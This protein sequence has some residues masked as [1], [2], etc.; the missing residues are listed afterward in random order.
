M[1]R[2]PL[3]LAVGLLVAASLLQAAAASWTYAGQADATLTIVNDSDETI[4][5]VFVMLFA[6]SDWGAD[7][8]GG[9]LPQGGTLVLDLPADVY[10]VRLL[11]C[12]GNEL[13]DRWVYVQESGELRFTEHDLCSSFSR[14]GV[15]LYSQSRYDEALQPLEAALACC[16]EG[17]DRDGEGTALYNIGAVYYSQ[18]T[19]AG[20]LEAYGQA[21]I[22]T[23]EVGD[24]V[25]EGATLN[26]IGF[27]YYAQGRYAEAFETYQQ[28][29]AIQ[30]E[31]GDQAGEARTL[32]NIGSVY[33]NQGRYAEAF[34]T[35]QQ[36]LVI[37]RDVG[38]R[39][40]E[41][42]TL[43][44][45]GSVYHNQGQYAEAF[46]TYQQALAIERDVGD[47]AGEARALSNI[48]S[49]YHNQGRYPE[50][51][52]V[53]GQALAIQ[54]EV[55]DRAGEAM[56][57][58]N[59]GMVFDAQ[60]RH[61]EALGVHQQALAIQREAGDRTGEAGTL[62]DIGSVYWAQGRYPEALEVNGQALAIQREV[63]DRAGEAV[64]LNNIGTVFDAQG[65]HVEALGVHQQALAI[66]REVGS[67]AGE[68]ATLHN[69]G[70]VYGNQGRYA[71]AIAACEEALAILREVG[72]RSGEGHTLSG[73]GSVYLAQGRCA[74]A[75][76]LF[77]RALAIEREVGDRRGQGETR[78]NVGNIYLLQG[79]YSEALEAYQKALAIHREVGNRQGEGRTLSSIGLVYWAQGRYPEA[80]DV[81]GQALAIQREVG[82]RAAE[83]RTLND[84]GAVYGA[85][86]RYAEALE[87]YRQALAV[88]REVGD[89]PSQGS[90]L[91]NMGRVLYD[92]DRHAEAL[93][94]YQQALAIEREVGD[95]VSEGITLS[96]I[97]LAYE[98]QGQAEQA[99]LYFRQ[100]MNVFDSLRT[101]AGSEAGRAGVGAQ[102]AWLYDRA[103]AL[104]HKSSQDETAFRT[105]ERG[106]ARAFLD[107]ISTGHVELSD[108]E[109]ADLLACEQETYAV[110]QAAQDALAKARALDP[111]DPALVA[112][113]EAQLAQS[114]T[115]YSAALAAIEDR[116]DQLA[117]LVPGRSTVLGLPTVQAL[118]D[119]ETTLLSYYVL[120]DE[121]SLA[122]L[123]T[124]DGFSVVD[125]PEATPANLGC[126]VQ[127]LYR[128]PN[129]ENPS[130]RPLQDLYAWLVAPLADQIATPR[131]GIIPH[132]ELNYVPFAALSDGQAYWGEEHALFT[133]SSAS[134]LPFIQQNA[135]QAHG[136]GA[137]VL[138]NPASGEAGL[139]PLVYAGEEAEGVAGLLGVGAL[140]GAEASET[141]LRTGVTGVGV[142]HLAAHGG[143]NT[144][145]PLYSTIYLAAGG[146]DD[147][148]L[149]VHEM[150]GLDL[151]AADLVVLSA[152]QSNLGELSAGDEWVGMTRALLFAGTPTV[153]AS[154]W[155]V[156]DKAA[157][158]LM[159]AFY[160]HWQSGM[161]KAEAL[162]AAQAEIR[163]RYPSPFYWA[164]FVL[165][166]DPGQAAPQAGP[167][168]SVAPS[169]TP[170]GSP[171]S[172]TTGLPWWVWVLLAV[173]VAGM[174]GLVVWRWRR[175][176]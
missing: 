159:M 9:T 168:P 21:L 24:E 28:A 56:T 150:Y 6:D 80:L 101:V 34:E 111:A 94:A 22:I 88:E 15:G 162:Q 108:N 117:A 98:P 10:D 151:K 87:A 155:S 30:R 45:I 163:A 69:I 82:D 107:S 2:L 95:R 52:E 37:Q 120:G 42:R 83:G 153:V 40:G 35:Y 115:D 158:E 11:D 106:R 12:E 86:R 121:G 70:S 49:A 109:A 44:N 20:A 29:L 165:S 119:E 166:G 3:L 129:L 112:D 17:G 46:E 66:E 73:M 173:L 97:G 36:A 157:G 100:A 91:N 76:H 7:R 71:E 13:L 137:L 142:V 167:V 122:F 78:G 19:Y 96:N 124:R 113:L 27:V 57:L 131:V 144:A 60:G 105:S 126:A 58:N 133:L 149:E 104:Y 156:D 84:I 145:N 171:N 176:R 134:A 172:A 130:P 140:T 128:W 102:H 54:R 16:R 67:R 160:R 169:A 138:G 170:A 77:H 63:G 123:V 62:S 33:H 39:A 47:R 55:G 41:A 64:T 8:L 18:G 127:D 25:R 89:R 99:A 72:D 75:L 4:C 38:D 161:G 90:T 174:T 93:E 51:L 53:N 65:R 81:N 135:Q 141:R 85:E 48:G 139:T 14:R 132:Q 114:E 125:L 103:V 74:D 147:G 152:C 32:S 50:A 59:I 143:F 68:G 61:A 146:S 92:Q 148:L 1:G 118:L 26:N 175:C 43:S 110:R 31:V 23:R 154:L 79:R 164:A 5:S 136:S 116:H